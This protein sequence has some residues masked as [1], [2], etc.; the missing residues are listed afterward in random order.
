MPTPSFGKVWKFLLAVCL[1]L[2]P[3][4]AEACRIVERPFS[5]TLAESDLEF[6]AEVIS[7]YPANS[8]PEADEFRYTVKLHGEYSQSPRNADFTFRRD[9]AQIRHTPQGDEYLSCPKIW[10][11]GIEG[12]LV[13]GEKYRFWL[14]SKN[15]QILWARRFSPDKKSAYAVKIVDFGIYESVRSRDIPDDNV[16]GGLTEITDKKLLQSTTTGPLRLNTSFGYRYRLSGPLLLAD[17]SIR[18]RHPL[19][20][21]PESGREFQR[22]AWGQSILTGKGINI[23]TGFMF[24]KE[25]MLVPG[26]WTIELYAGDELLAEKKF[27]L[28]K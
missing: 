3:A 17:V 7:A 13:P 9:K 18:V 14:D 10:G 23:N 11:S 8:R 2:A 5:D 21:D 25:W 15:N 16:A 19:L 22:S 4:V 27:T 20:R 28:V 6:T 24:D 12:R 1:T 26:D